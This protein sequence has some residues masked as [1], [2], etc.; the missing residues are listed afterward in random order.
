[1]KEEFGKN[2]VLYLD[3]CDNYFESYSAQYFDGAIIQDYFNLIGL[4]ATI[5][6]NHEFLYRRKWVEEKIKKAKYPVLVNNLQDI[7]TKKKKEF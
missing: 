2:R 1:M 6:G 3:T 7:K 4:N 5:L